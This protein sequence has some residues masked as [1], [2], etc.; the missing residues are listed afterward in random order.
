MSD[1]F[2]R[3][4]LDPIGDPFAVEAGAPVRAPPSVAKVPAPTRSRTRALRVG[5][6]IAAL[7]FDA[8][9]LVFRETRPDL[10]SLPPSQIAVGIAVPLIAAALALAAASRTG[11]RGL[12]LPA[13]RVAGLAGALLAPAVARS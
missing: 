5:A 8:A 11:P 6:L 9:W 1:E 3:M 10:A 12:G 4:R 7:L 13:T 2:D